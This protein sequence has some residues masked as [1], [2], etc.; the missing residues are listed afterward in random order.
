MEENQ[1]Q[2]PAKRVD[3]V[4]VKLEITKTSPVLISYFIAFDDI[5]NIKSIE[6][7][8]NVLY[9]KFSEYYIY[10][11]SIERKERLKWHY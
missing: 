3:I 8:L 10:S 4:S 2:Q 11:F 9:T 5:Q 6:M 7:S 1:K